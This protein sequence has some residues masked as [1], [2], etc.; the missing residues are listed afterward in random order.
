MIV[1]PPS[2]IT[3]AIARLQAGQFGI[4][5][6]LPEKNEAFRQIMRY[7]MGFQ[8]DGEKWYR[9]LDDCSGPIPDRL[10]ET[11][12]MLFQAGF[13]IEIDDTLATRLQTGCWQ[14]EQKRW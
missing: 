1:S 6:R 7:K 13:I 14:P 5:A 2:P 4:I 9:R 8:W 11:A 12:A 3:N 10:L